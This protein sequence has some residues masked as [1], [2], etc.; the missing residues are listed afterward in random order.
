MRLIRDDMER[1]GDISNRQLLLELKELFPT[2]VGT[3]SVVYP[4][5]PSVLETF[6]EL[7]SVEEEYDDMDGL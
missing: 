5:L 2:F 4:P 7:P 1:D 3:S 6:N